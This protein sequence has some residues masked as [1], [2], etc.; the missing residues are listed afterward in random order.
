[1]SLRAELEPYDRLSTLSRHDEGFANIA[2]EVWS[3]FKNEFTHHP[4]HIIKSGAMGAAAGVGLGVIAAAGGPVT[5]AV[6]G[7]TAAAVLLAPKVEKFINGGAAELKQDL[8]VAWRPQDHNQF[9]VDKADAHMNRIG[10]SAADQ[11]VALLAGGLTTPATTS[12]A[13]GLRAEV[14][15][16]KTSL[17][18]TAV[19][20][21]APVFELPP[22]GKS[23]NTIA[24]HLTPDEAAIATEHLDIPAD[25]FNQYKPDTGIIMDYT[26]KFS[27]A[28]TWAEMA[29]QDDGSPMAKMALDKLPDLLRKTKT[30]HEY[31]GER[32]EAYEHDEGALQNRNEVESFFGDREPV[33]QLDHEAEEIRHFADSDLGNPATLRELIDHMQH[34]Q[35]IIYGPK[36][37]A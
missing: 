21:A 18:T 13:S 3:G 15:A 4:D 34:A 31:L 28:R 23:A 17:E 10:A 11:G 7:G 9:E 36:K 27:A 22:L 35:D 32:I 8:A 29:L 2:R 14:S 37:E 33:R 25:F 5:A 26:N 12:L 30:Y 16:G 19:K 24:H 1:M 6:I 20:E